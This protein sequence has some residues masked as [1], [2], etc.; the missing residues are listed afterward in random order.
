VHLKPASEIAVSIVIF[1]IIAE[2]GLKIQLFSRMEGIIGENNSAKA[3]KIAYIRL[4]RPRFLR[5]ILVF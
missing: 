2:S 4:Y 3:A 5:I 1:I